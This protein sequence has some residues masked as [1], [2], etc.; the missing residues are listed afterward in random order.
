LG[1][2]T[3]NTGLNVSSFSQFYISRPPCSTKVA[4]L[5]NI[6][7]ETLRDVLSFV[8]AGDTIKYFSGINANLTDSLLVYKSA[9][10]K[11]NGVS[12]TA[13]NMAYNPGKGIVIPAGVTVTLMDLMLIMPNSP[14]PVI[15]NNGNLILNNI[16]V[17]G[18]STINSIVLNQGAGTVTIRNNNTI[19]K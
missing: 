13:I 1:S 4:S 7:L 10:I 11:G 18:N 12:Q 14:G 17:E 5:G 2:T 6:G 3:F 16:T 15:V 8:S 9:V 19:K